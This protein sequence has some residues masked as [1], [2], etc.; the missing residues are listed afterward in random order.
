MRFTTVTT[1]RVDGRVGQSAGSTFGPRSTTHSP[2]FGTRPPVGTCVRLFR[3]GPCRSPN[4][5]SPLACCTWGRSFA[6]LSLMRHRTR[7]SM[8]AAGRSNPACVRTDHRHDQ[9]SD[10]ARHAVGWSEEGQAS[11]PQSTPLR[12]KW[13]RPCPK[14][15]SCRRASCGLEERGMN[16]SGPVIRRTVQAVRGRGSCSR[17]FLSF[18]LAIATRHRLDELLDTAGDPHVWGNISSTRV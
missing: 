12:R 8:S 15:R 9:F 14:R 13:G 3:T 1:P 18:G 5:T 11:C 10:I 4:H 2:H 16:P 7:D 6:N 17:L